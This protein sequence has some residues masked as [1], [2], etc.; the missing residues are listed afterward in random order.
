MREGQKNYIGEEGF[1][2]GSFFELATTIKIYVNGL[3]LH[4][5]RNEISLEYTGDFELNRS[6]V[7]G[8]F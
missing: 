7:S 8:L 1:N 3:T 5:P 6:M 4:E 2:L